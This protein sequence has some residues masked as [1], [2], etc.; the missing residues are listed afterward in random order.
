MP[1]AVVSRWELSRRLYNRRKHL[2]VSVN[3][4]A[5]TLNFSRNYWSAVEN[6]RTLIAEDK[7]RALFPLLEFDRKEQ[8]ELLALREEARQRSWWDRYSD[9][10]ESDTMRFLGLEDGAVTIDTF[11]SLSVPALLQTEPY[12]RAILGFD[13][14][15]SKLKIDQMV[16]MRAERQQRVL[17]DGNA[18]YTA[19]LSEASIRQLWT[20]VDN[21]VD[22]LGFLRDLVENQTIELRILPID[23][24][25]GLIAAVSAL[26]LMTF[27]S[28][29][30][31]N[32]FWQESVLPLGVIDETDHHHYRHLATCLADGMKRSLDQE[33]SLQ[34]LTE[35]LASVESMQN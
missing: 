9:G 4:I 34:R 23:L 24:P 21:H 32:V 18:Q 11:A 28:E 19:L 12:A 10:T 3:T 20:S 31:P 30:L 33:A 15:L 22:Q 26:V 2:G 6:D 25:P 5:E 14:S 35:A 16:E 27:P 1:S 7:L 13:P 17:F 29:H 8:R